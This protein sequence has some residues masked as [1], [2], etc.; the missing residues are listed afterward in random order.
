MHQP[1]RETESETGPAG[2]DLVRP[3]VVVVDPD[4]NHLG[5]VHR[6]LTQSGWQVWA[7]TGSD[8]AE[9]AFTEHADEVSAV[10]VDL[11]Q[12]GFVGGRLLAECGVIQPGVVRCGMASVSPYMATAFRRMSGIPILPKPFDVNESGRQLRTMLEE[13]T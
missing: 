5:L 10:L 6:S 9:R 2:A 12:P 13:G 1:E 7:F 4:A 11:E 8:E 3:V